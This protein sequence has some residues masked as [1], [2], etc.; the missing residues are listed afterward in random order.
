MFQFPDK[1]LQV[2]RDEKHQSDFEKNGFVI[3]PFYTA[4]EIIALENLYHRLHPQNE[5]GFFPST[6][7]KDKNYRYEADSE[8]KRIGNRSI[9]KYCQDIKV[10]C[11]SFI[12]K[13]PGPESGMCVHQDMSLIDESRFT[14]INIWVPLVDLTIENGALF[15]LPGSHRI[16]PTYRGSSIPEFFAPV[17]ENMI[18]YL[19]PVLIKAGEAVFFDQSIIHFS[20]PN[21]SAGIR[22]VTNTYFTH[23]NTE[24]RTYY[25]NKDEHKNAVE[26]FAQDDDFMTNF[27]QFGDNIRDR[28]K[29]GK[30][31]GLVEYNFPTIDKAFLDNRFQR[32]NARRLIENAKPKIEKELTPKTIGQLESRSMSFFERLKELVG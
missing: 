20:P 31:L 8:I 11:G 2:F 16:F 19:Q 1:M 15:V 13:S 22:I 7:S 21:Y 30:S 6:F 17:M 25:W 32:T 28:P 24:Y 4:E 27:E 14:G 10:V 5:Q 26:A 12:V 18:D 9:E 23:K 3:L 29:V